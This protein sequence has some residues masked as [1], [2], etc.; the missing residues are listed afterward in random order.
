MD[1][2]IDE[3]GGHHVIAKDVAPLLEAFV[4]RE[5]RGRMLL[6]ACHELKEEHRARAGDREV[7]DLIDDE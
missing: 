3:R 7:A 4:G 6:A 1:E 2:A 5:H